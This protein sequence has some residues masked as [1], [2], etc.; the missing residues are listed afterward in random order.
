MQQRLCSPS[1]LL[2]LCGPQ[3]ERLCCQS[4]LPIEC[5][6]STTARRRSST[7][8]K[9][10]AKQL[11][12]ARRGATSMSCAG[13]HELLPVWSTLNTS[14]IIRA[15]LPLEQSRPRRCQCQICILRVDLDFEAF[16]CM[17]LP[18]KQHIPQHH[19]RKEI[20]RLQGQ[21]MRQAAHLKSV[22]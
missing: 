20:C 22:S 6:L 16:P 3:W 17:H 18:G 2:Q 12:A 14:K 13:W 7:E 8:Y 10:A 9:P 11:L 1:L 4:T 15:M 19:N 5:L 21:R